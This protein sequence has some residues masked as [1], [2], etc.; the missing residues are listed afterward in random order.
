MSPKLSI[1]TM[2]LPP[3]QPKIANVPPMTKLPLVKIKTKILK[4]LEK[5]KLNK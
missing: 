1:V 5:K 3:K 2:S 4:L